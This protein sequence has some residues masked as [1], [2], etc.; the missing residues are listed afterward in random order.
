MSGNGNVSLNTFLSTSKQTWLESNNSNNVTVVIGNESCDLDTAVSSI[1]Y[2]YLTFVNHINPVG[3]NI[4]VIL[5]VLNVER[6][7]YPVKTEVKYFFSCNNISEDDLI[8]R[9]EIDLVKLHEEKKLKLI[10]VDHHVL[11]KDYQGL[12]SSVVKVLDHRPKDKKS[13]WTDDI[14]RIELVG[15]CCTLVGDEIVKK[16]KNIL[17]NNHDIANLIYGTIVLDTFC[18][19]EDV[20][21][22]TALDREVADHCKQLGDISTPEKDLCDKLR[23]SRSDISLLTPAQILIKDMKLVEC[24]P[25]STLTTSVEAFLSKSDSDHHVKSVCEAL[26][27]PL[28]IILGVVWDGDTLKR[29]VYIYCCSNYKNDKVKDKGGPEALVEFIIRHLNDYTLLD[30]KFIKDIS[31]GC[32]FRQTN[33]KLT[34]KH[35]LPIVENA[36]KDFTHE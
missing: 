4:D 33:T 12:E 16:N 8:F 15:S 10:L 28:F 17:S 24:I 2:S 35:I 32:L 25:I 18:F 34:R 11:Q 31:S 6:K 3:D 5:P 36:Y 7:N 19:N 21:R 23:E 9:D 22:Y 1:V 13:K 27:A 29:D 30:L 26:N 14:A 20:K